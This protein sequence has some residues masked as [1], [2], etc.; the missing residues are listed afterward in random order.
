MFNLVLNLRKTHFFPLVVECRDLCLTGIVPSF[1]WSLSAPEK[2]LDF[3][4]EE[5]HSFSSRAGE[6]P[7]YPMARWLG[8][9]L[10]RWEMGV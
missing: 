1:A 7:E 3:F 8:Y 6:H 2:N 4:P 9:S 5:Q 10:M